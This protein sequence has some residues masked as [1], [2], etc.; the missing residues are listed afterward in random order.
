MIEIRRLH[1]NLKGMK[2][3]RA[4]LSDNTS[5]TSKCNFQ[6]SFDALSAFKVWSGEKGFWNLVDN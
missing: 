1:T 3:R 2:T 6:Y 5:A 4:K